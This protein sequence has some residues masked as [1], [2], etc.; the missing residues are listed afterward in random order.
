MWYLTDYPSTLSSAAD[1]ISESIRLFGQA[2]AVVMSSHVFMLFM[3]F[4]LLA[5]GFG[6][7]YILSRSGRK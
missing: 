4:M 1:F 2:L 6:L 5:V 7:I 3:A